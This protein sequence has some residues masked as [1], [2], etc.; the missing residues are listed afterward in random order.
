[1]RRA[2]SQPAKC[3]GQVVVAVPPRLLSRI[4][5]KLEDHPGAGCYLAA[6]ADD[7]LTVIVIGHAS[8]RITSRKKGTPPI[9]LVQPHGHAAGRMIW[10]TP[11]PTFRPAS[12]HSR[13]PGVTPAELFEVSASMVASKLRMHGMATSAQI[14]QKIADLAR[15][16]ADVEKK[17][18]EADARRSNKESED[19][20]REASASRASSDS[21]RRSF[22]RQAES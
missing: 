3:L 8:H 9:A 10:S 12:S 20:A 18:S 14:R 21:S 19:A 5:N 7:A 15:Q 13:H 1:M 4:G 2:S 11:L 17:I 6:C 22:L 16:H